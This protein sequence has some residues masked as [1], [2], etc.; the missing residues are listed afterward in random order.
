VGR[1]DCGQ[2]KGSNALSCKKRFRA[3]LRGQ[4]VICLGIPDNYA[5]MDPELVELLKKRVAWHPPLE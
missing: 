5:F 4:R 1:H 3:A 2:R